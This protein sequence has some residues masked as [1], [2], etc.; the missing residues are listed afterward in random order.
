MANQKE[1]ASVQ[2]A[3]AL[4]PF[5][6]TDAMTSSNADETI[7]D[8]AKG[9]ERIANDNKQELVMRCKQLLS[10]LDYSTLTKFQRDVITSLE[11][12]F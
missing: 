9:I 3:Q 2:F 11:R 4:R 12:N 8:I 1:T 10:S 6:T 7:K 5:L